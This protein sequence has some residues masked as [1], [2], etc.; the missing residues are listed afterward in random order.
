MVHDL[1]GS[2]FTNPK[3]RSATSGGPHAAHHPPGVTMTGSAMWREGLQSILLQAPLAGE[4]DKLGT[5]YGDN[6]CKRHRKAVRDGK[7][8][9]IRSIPH[10]PH[11]YLIPAGHGME[12]A[13]GNI[14]G[15]Q[16]WNWCSLILVLY[17]EFYNILLIIPA[18]GTIDIEVLSFWFSFSFFS[19]F[20]FFSAHVSTVETVKDYCR[21]Q[22]KWHRL[23]YHTF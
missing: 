3:T 21:S 7:K 1:M 17:C 14:Q 20:L 23:K 8:G 16:F 18:P 5:P 12:W 6:R 11:D 2:H 15:H 19:A 13:E 9:G 4:G 10:L 22:I